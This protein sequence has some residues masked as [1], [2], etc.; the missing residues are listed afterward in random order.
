MRQT[1]SDAKAISKVEG[2]V[3]YTKSSNRKCQMATA[4][5]PSPH[6]CG[7]GQVQLVGD[8]VDGVK[9]V[10]RKFDQAVP[11]ATDHR[12]TTAN[13]CFFMGDPSWHEQP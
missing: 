10:G 9:V 2:E 13:R 3:S 1:V 6:T 5:I 12:Q 4:N 8:A 11:L 7:L